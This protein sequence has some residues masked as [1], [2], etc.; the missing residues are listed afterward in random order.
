MER[1]IE[2]QFTASVGDSDSEN[3]ADDGEQSGLN[4]RFAHQQAARRAEG[5]TQRRLR[6]LLQAASEHEIGEISASDKQHTAGR[7]EQ[8][9]QS[10]LVLVA[11]GCGACASGGE[12]QG[13][14]TPGLLF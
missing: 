12:M 7:D 2:N 9:L 4:E 1:E 11:H 8:Q 6:A 13:L 5:D 14:L 3:T 10:S